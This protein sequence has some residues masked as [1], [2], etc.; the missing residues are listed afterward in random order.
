MP[1]VESKYPKTEECKKLFLASPYYTWGEFCESMSWEAQACRQRYPVPAWIAEKIKI[2]N[3][4]FGV[5][6]DGIMAE[7][8]E[9]WYREVAKTIHEY[10]KML[11]SVAQVVKHR[12]NQ[13]LNVIMSDLKNGTKEFNKIPTSAISRLATAAERITRAKYESLLLT[14]MKVKEFE[15]KADGS[16]KI[17]FEIAG[18][19]SVENIKK[20]MEDW[21]NK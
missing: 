1:R 4:I 9:H 18:G 6:I 19:G 3:E 15:G 20:I 7:Q 5:E 12:T 14:E 10:P 8:S 11:D 13:Y 2:Q 21:S 16:G 17:V